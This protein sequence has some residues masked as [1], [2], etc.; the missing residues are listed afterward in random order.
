[1]TDLCGRLHGLVAAMPRL[2]F[3]FDVKRVPKNGIYIL[4]EK[5]ETAHGT[6]RIVRVG[7]HTGDRQLQ[8][9]LSQHFINEN[10]DRSIF[11]KNIGRAL[12]NRDQDAF[13]AQWEIDLTTR[14]A[15]QQHAGKIDSGKL[16]LTEKKVTD[17]MRAGFSFCVLEVT[18][19]DDRLALE[20]KLLSTVSLCTNC[21]PSTSWLG[22]HSPKQ[23]I[24]ESGLW[25]VNE[26]FKTPLLS[27]E[28]QTLALLTQQ[29]F[30]ER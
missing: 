19:K 9:R 12:L 10:K 21:G 5:G 2:R 24:R 27:A 4:F 26:L 1:M 3:P 17:Y 23:R 7:T 13:L 18:G 14:V 22:R 6:D 11:R 29:G 28:L 25:N 15:K 8:S 30:M 20:S 16:Q